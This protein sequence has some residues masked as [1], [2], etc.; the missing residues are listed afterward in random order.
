[1]PTQTDIATPEEPEQPRESLQ[2]ARRKL[3]V[4]LTQLLYAR[5]LMEMQAWRSWLEGRASFRKAM[6][7]TVFE[8]LQD[9]AQGRTRLE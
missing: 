3:A 8:V 7:E 4:D 9:L 5:Q 1:M 6:R 2:M